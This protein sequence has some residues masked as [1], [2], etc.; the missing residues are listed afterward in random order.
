MFGRSL[1]A[2]NL[3]SL[4]GVLP[5]SMLECAHI[6]WSVSGHMCCDTR[7]IIACTSNLF[8]WLCWEEVDGNSCGLGRGSLIYL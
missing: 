3:A 7:Q 2:P 4:L 6:F 1:L 5:L 8:G